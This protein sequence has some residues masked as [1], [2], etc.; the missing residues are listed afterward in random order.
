[1]PE[2]T[3]LLSTKAAIRYLLPNG[4]AGL[5]RSFVKGWSRSRLPP[6]RMRPRTRGW[7][8]RSLCPGTRCRSGLEMCRDVGE[9]EVLGLLALE[10]LLLVPRHGSPALDS[11]CKVEQAG[12]VR[13][14]LGEPR[15]GVVARRPR[16]DEK[17][18]VG[19][20]GEQQ[21][22]GHLR[23]DPAQQR[24][25]PP[26]V[27]GRERP[28]VLLG[29]V[30]HLPGPLRVLVHPHPVISPLAPRSFEARDRLAGGMRIE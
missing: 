13:A 10:V 7:A 25:A 2:L 18:P 15:L 6:A 14:V 4:T 28:E 16:G 20:L 30:D 21:L 12:E 9:A 19:G 24:G 17:L 11:P 26:P 23:D 27:R 8:M 29:L 5:L 1:M 3:K 22:A